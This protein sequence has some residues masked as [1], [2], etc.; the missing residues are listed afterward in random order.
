MQEIGKFNK[1][2]NVISNNMEK[3][4]AFMIDRN[5]IFIDSFQFMNQSLSDLANNLPKDGFYHTKNEFGSNNLELITKKGVYPYDYMDDFNK[6]KEEGLPS[7]ENFY[8]KLTDEDISD[9][10][11]NH[12][13]MFG[14]NLNVKQWEIIMIFI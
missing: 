13:K 7:I 11:Y 1:G 5:L 6:F 9:K 10:Y 4:M 3:Y 8:S 2:I 12:A 14:K